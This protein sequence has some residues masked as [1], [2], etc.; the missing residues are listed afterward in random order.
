VYRHSVPTAMPSSKATDRVTVKQSPPFHA[1]RQGNGHGSAVLIGP[2][3]FPAIPA[4]TGGA[5]LA[6]VGP[7]T[8]LCTTC[9][10]WPGTAAD[11]AISQGDHLP[12]DDPHP[13]SGGK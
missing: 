3:R 2:P 8:G 11:K 1:G 6:L 12:M 5:F 10:H 4:G 13:P 7:I 9:A